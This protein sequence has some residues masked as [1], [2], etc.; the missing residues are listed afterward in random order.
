MDMSF[1]VFDKKDVQCTC[2]ASGRGMCSLA[3]WMGRWQQMDT[4]RQ[5]VDLVSLT[6]TILLSEKPLPLAQH[7]CG[8]YCYLLQNTTV[9]LRSLAVCIHGIFLSTS[10]NSKPTCWTSKYEMKCTRMH[11]VTISLQCTILYYYI[12]FIYIYRIWSFRLWHFGMASTAL[13]ASRT[14]SFECWSAASR[15]RHDAW[16]QKDRQSMAIF[17]YK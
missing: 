9:A 4:C 5:R 14:K 2:F 10:R 15:S 7:F 12:I 16:W 11:Y 6:A 13:A 3:V 1:W 17:Q 8:C